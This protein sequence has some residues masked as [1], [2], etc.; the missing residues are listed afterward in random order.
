MAKS[1]AFVKDKFPLGANTQG[2]VEVTSD[3]AVVGFEMLN[4]DDPTHEAWGL[5]AIEGQPA[6]LNIYF[7]HQVINSK[8]WTL[9]ALANPDDSATATVTLIAYDDAGT[10]V[11]TA[12]PGIPAN[13]NLAQL[14]KSLFGF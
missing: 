5:A 8:W 13:G 6:G 11:K 4:A 9:F 1:A 12:T 3:P 2:W 7:P 14:V 10:Q